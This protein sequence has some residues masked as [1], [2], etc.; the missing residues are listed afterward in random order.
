MLYYH[1]DVQDLLQDWDWEFLS[2][3]PYVPGLVP[4]DFFLFPCVKK[5]MRRHRFEYADIIN[6]AIMVSLCHLRR[7]DYMVAADH[8][9]Q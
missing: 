9:A 2:H 3:P 7:N 5:L 6:I 8:L 4:W 1:P